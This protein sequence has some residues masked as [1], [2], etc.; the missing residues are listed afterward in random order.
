MTRA[1]KA[2]VYRICDEKNKSSFIG[3]TYNLDGILKRFR[4]ELNMNMCTLKPLQAM[5]N[6]ARKQVSYDILEEVEVSAAGDVE[7]DAH[8]KACMYKWQKKLEEG[9]ETVKIILL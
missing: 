3:Y 9:G 8:L 6:A 4:F 2:G 7:S 1:L 5:F